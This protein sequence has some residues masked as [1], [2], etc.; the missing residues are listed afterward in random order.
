M[1]SPCERII[2][3]CLETVCLSFVINKPVC[4]LK[5]SHIFF[6]IVLY[7]SFKGPVTHVGM[8]ISWACSWAFRFV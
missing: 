6:S 4:Y 2:R 8:P 5:V 7:F 3:P 1:F